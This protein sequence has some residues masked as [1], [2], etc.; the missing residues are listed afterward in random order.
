MEPFFDSEYKKNQ[1]FQGIEMR[2]DPRVY[3]TDPIPLSTS[4]TRILPKTDYAA[5]ID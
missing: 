2:R 4:N 5:R 3:K 1:V